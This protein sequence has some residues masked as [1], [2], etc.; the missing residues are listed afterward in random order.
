[1]G[2][3]EKTPTNINQISAKH[4][5]QEDQVL[6]GAIHLQYAVCKNCASLC[7]MGVAQKSAWLH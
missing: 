3:L 7:A 1:M 2:W 4:G 5:F 6:F